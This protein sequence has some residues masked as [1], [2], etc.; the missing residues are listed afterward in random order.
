MPSTLD[1][2]DR[3]ILEDFLEAV[4]TLAAQ[5][6]KTY[7]ELGAVRRILVQ[8]GTFHQDELLEAFTEFE[9]SSADE[10]LI[11]DRPSIHVVDALLRRSREQS[12]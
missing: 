3:E 11:Q 5:T 9:A 4:R 7:L 1:A 10:P 6:L 2:R 12:G 8:N